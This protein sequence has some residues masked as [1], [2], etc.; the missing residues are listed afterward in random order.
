MTIKLKS[1]LF[2]CSVLLLIA[3]NSNQTKN[4][5]TTEI[6]QQKISDKPT[7]K[8]TQVDFSGSYLSGNKTDGSDWTE[9]NIESLKGGDSFQ[10]SVDAKERKGKKSCNFNKIGI[11]RNDTLFIE[12]TDWKKP[13]TA[14]IVKKED[15][16]IFDVIEK[17][18]DDRYVLSYY[19]SGGGSLIGEYTKTEK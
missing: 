8:N 15:K 17:E 4:N 9:V 18:E 7:N 10:V 1:F 14:Y 5:S 13:V 12:T 16:I 11:V 19:C 2:T 3:C 6:E